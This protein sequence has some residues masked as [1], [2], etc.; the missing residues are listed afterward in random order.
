MSV[1][2]EWCVAVFAL[3]PEQIKNDLPY[4]YNFIN[5]TDGVK[6]THFLTKD[7]INDKVVFSFRVMIDLKLKRIIKSKIVYKLKNMIPSEDFAVEP[8]FDS[9]LHKFVEWEPEKRIAE[10]GLKKFM[11]LVAFLSRTS[12]FAVDMIENDF[13]ASNERVQLVQAMAGVLGCTE[14]GKLSSKAMELGYYDRID[15]KYCTHLK[16]EYQT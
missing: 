11:D 2:D 5:N 9:P 12:K 8:N 16:E 1:V 13:F 6:N 3:K 14:Y 10:I 4:F 7:R 15:D